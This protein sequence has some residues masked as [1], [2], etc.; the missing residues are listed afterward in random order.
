MHG[1]LLRPTEVARRL[2]VSRSWLYEA[3]RTGVIPSI[4]LGGPDG[5]LRFVQE[6]LDDWLTASR[7]RVVG[8]DVDG[9]FGPAGRTQ[10]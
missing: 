8:G 1:D 7:G 4:R 3:A 5:P 6:E 2:C 9:R 10:S